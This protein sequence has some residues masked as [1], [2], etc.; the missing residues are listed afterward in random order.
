MTPE[1]TPLTEKE[2][3]LRQAQ[4]G[5]AAAQSASAAGGDSDD[6][7]G[8]MRAASH[9]PVAEIGG[10]RLHGQTLQVVLCLQMLEAHVGN[11]GQ[12]LAQMADAQGAPPV[13][14]MLMLARLGYILTHPMDAYEALADIA[15]AS[16][17]SDKA[18]ELRY[19]DALAL[20]VTGGW[21][22][23]EMAQLTRHLL[24]LGKQKT[25]IQSA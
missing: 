8:L 9:V 4:A 16:S 14:A 22:P 12:A 23:D 7:H 13:P 15:N 18:Q 10:Y 20:E 2:I 3:T 24:T 21:G 6:I 17:E 5:A 1:S 25:P 19:L 11:A